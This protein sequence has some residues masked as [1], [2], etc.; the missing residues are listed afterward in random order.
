[1]A[2]TTRFACCLKTVIT[3]F[4][5]IDYIMREAAKW[6]EDIGRPTWFQEM[7]TRENL[8]QP[9]GEF[10]VMYD[11]GGNSVA[12]L[13]CS[14]LRNSDLE[15]WPNL[16]ESNN[17]FIHKMAI[18][19]AFAAQGLAK[20]LMQ[21]TIEEYKKMNFSA[22]YLDCRADYPYPSAFYKDIGFKLIETKPCPFKS[23]RIKTVSLLKMEL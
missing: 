7:L 10:I 17:G 21:F 23:P 5:L 19:R 14:P 18:R 9:A 4:N 15:F 12:T 2:Q 13:I 3:V 8:T 6:L 1:M 22:I 20:K 16:P 11:D